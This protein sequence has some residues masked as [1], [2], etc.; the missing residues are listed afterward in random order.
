M[1][2][3]AHVSRLLADADRLL[4]ESF[5]RDELAAAITIGEARGMIA[6]AM[7]LLADTEGTERPG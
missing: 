2:D 3:L 7:K 5:G 1:P 6:A 4:R